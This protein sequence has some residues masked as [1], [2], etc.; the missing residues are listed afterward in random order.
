VLQLSPGRYALNFWFGVVV[1]LLNSK[2]SQQDRADESEHGAYGEHIQSQGKVH[3]SA[4]LVEV[5]Q[6]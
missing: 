2:C 4:S 5:E 3:G 1:A 6:A